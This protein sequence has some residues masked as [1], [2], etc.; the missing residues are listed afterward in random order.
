MHIK[1]SDEQH[2]MSCGDNFSKLYVRNNIKFI[3]DFLTLGLGYQ[4]W[5][6]VGPLFISKHRYNKLS[7]N[8]YDAI[9]NT[10]L[11]LLG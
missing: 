10:N 2:Q 8:P 4:G 5:R 6:L 3:F 11:V 9:F 1:L 7:S